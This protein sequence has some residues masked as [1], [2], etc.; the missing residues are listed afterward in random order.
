MRYPAGFSV[1][2]D[3][4]GI[5]EL[6]FESNGS[7]VPPDY[8]YRDKLRVGSSLA[9]AFDVMGQPDKVV[10]GEKLT[11][12]DGVL[13]KDCDGRKG[14]IYYARRK[15]GVR[16]FL[17]NDKVTAVYVTPIADPQPVISEPDAK[18]FNTD[19]PSK[20]AQINLH[21]SRKAVIGI[22]GRPVRYFN[23]DRTLSRDDLPASY[24]MQYPAGVCVYMAGDGVS[25]LGFSNTGSV[26]PNF[27]FRDKL[28]VG[29]T[30]AEVVQVL[31]RPDRVV[32]GGHVG[33]DEG[34]FYKDADGRQGFGCYIRASLGIRVFL[35]SGKVTGMHIQPGANTGDE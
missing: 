6:R 5:R 19:L 20:V 14:F 23:G 33:S 24:V 8:A 7:D 9:E 4:D 25:A 10:E 3:G 11:F 34:V 31:G 29:S 15:E 16:I 12:K 18:A 2:M 27:G 28:R 26:K 32:Q 22:F 13:Y 1:F 30:A 35:Q 21:A 17:L